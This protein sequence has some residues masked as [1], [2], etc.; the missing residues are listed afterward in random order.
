VEQGRKEHLLV[1]G[2]QEQGQQVLG[3]LVNLLESD[4]LVQDPQ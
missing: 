4:L 1:L 2:Q 3:L